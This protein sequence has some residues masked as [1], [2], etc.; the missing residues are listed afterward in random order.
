VIST[1]KI[2]LMWRV[3]MPMRGSSCR[4]V[5]GKPVVALGSWSR[6]SAIPA[7]A[8]AICCGGWRQH[9]PESLVVAIPALPD[10]A[11]PFRFTLKQV[12]SGLCRV[13]RKGSPLERPIDRLL[14]DVIYAQTYDLLDAAR[15]GMYQGPTAVLKQLGPLCL[16]GGRRRALGDFAESAQKIWPQIEPGLRSYLLTLPTENSL[17]ATARQVLVQFP[18]ADRRALVTAWL[19]GEELAA[20]DRERIGAKQTINQE[21]T[22]RYVLCS[23]MRLASVRRP[24]SITILFDQADQLL[25]RA[26]AAGPA[27]AGRG[28]WLAARAGR[29]DA[30]DP[31]VSARY[32]WSVF[33]KA[34]AARSQSAQACG[35]RAW[36]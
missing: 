27:C 9:R 13:D 25:E 6:W 18:Y 19:A 35:G 11:Q 15:V 3:F 5:F 21:A 14:W 23:L 29:G 8:R 4:G 26:G 2:W 31:V 1:T 32:L 30:A 36:S 34:G 33:R 24:A 10:L 12:V 7:A 20:K 22:A 16:D 28:D 17:D